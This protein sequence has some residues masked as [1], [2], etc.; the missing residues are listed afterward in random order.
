MLPVSCAAVQVPPAAG[1]DGGAGASAVGDA[2]VDG[3]LDGASLVASVVGDV[4]PSADGDSDG[5][6][7]ADADADAA[8]DAGAAV[9]PSSVADGAQPLTAIRVPAAAAAMI[10]RLL[11]SRLVMPSP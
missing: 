4:D 6:A 10:Q 3:A 11:P 7:S 5:A 2:D 9:P 1:S 8:V